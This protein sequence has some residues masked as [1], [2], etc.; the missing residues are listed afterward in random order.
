MRSRRVG[1]T[2]P[3][4]GWCPRFAKRKQ[5]GPKSDEEVDQSAGPK[6]VEEVGQ[7]Q[8]QVMSYFPA[9]KGGWR[10]ERLRRYWHVGMATLLEVDPDV[11]SWTTEAETVRRFL[12][13]EDSVQ[14]TPHM[15]VAARDSYRALRLIDGGDGS[16]ERWLG[17]NGW[18]RDRCRENGANLMVIT[19]EEVE[20]HPIL[21]MAK[22]ILYHRRWDVPEE[23]ALRV[24]AMA[25]HPPAT[26]GALHAALDPDEGAWPQV[27]ALIG[28]GLIE[29]E[30]SG[31]LAPS[32]LVVACLAREA[33]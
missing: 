25:D 33:A 13:P 21:K 31:H 9:R 29:I 19:R 30:M 27:L 4:G 32:V 20:T 14:F 16:R 17:R 18:V 8:T 24:A 23:Y 7:R 11:L 6:P 28:Q 12:N 10:M 22:T 3:K 15:W 1:A 26:L 5:A 2:P